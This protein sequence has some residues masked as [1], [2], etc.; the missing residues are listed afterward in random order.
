MR[1]N[2][3]QSSVYL[4]P[5]AS[6]ICY[7]MVFVNK[8][9]QEKG[10]AWVGSLVQNLEHQ[11]QARIG[12][13]TISVPGEG[14]LETRLNRIREYAANQAVNYQTMLLALS[15][16][17]SINGDLSL[18]FDPKTG[19][20]MSVGRGE[21]IKGG[22]ADWILNAANKMLGKQVLNPYHHADSAMWKE[23]LFRGNLNLAAISLWTGGGTGRH[24]LLV[25]QV[26]G[27]RV[28]F[29]DSYDASKGYFRALFKSAKSEGGN[30]WSVDIDELLNSG[31]IA[32]TITNEEK[33]AVKREIPE[34]ILIG[35]E[36]FVLLNEIIRESLQ[37]RSSK[38]LEEDQARRRQ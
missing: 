20:V 33:F 35:L 22:H 29:L 25:E 12:D 9:R 10:K 5:E 8:L 37:G 15:L 2:I 1:L 21:S 28:V 30:R 19:E 32:Y 17:D 6:A 14:S 24:I 3:D 16:A 11:G 36:D 23:A 4:Q 18:V 27:N 31:R 7:A 26:V 13:L 34:R 38:Y